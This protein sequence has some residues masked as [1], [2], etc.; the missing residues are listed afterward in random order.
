MLLL[1]AGG[2]IATSFKVDSSDRVHLVSYLREAKEEAINVIKQPML[3][4]YEV[5][6]TA[7]GC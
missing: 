1:A 6:R 5:D 7:R 3:A 4:D 2:M